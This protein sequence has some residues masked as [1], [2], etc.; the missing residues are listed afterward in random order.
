MNGS[1]YTA[2]ASGLRVP[3][4]ELAVPHQAHL[5]KEVKVVLADHDKARLAGDQERFELR[6]RGLERYVAERHANARF[7]EYGSCQQRLQRRIWLHLLHLLRVGEQV[8]AVCEQDI[9][10]VPLL[11][12]R[13]LP[14]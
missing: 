13:A 5:G 2:A 3:K 14:R 8:I 4:R 1:G 7:A 10:H 11:R 6:L 9:S 12:S